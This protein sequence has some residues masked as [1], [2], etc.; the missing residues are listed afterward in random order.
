MNDMVVP[1]YTLISAIILP[2]LGLVIIYF[3][4]KL[5][6]KNGVR[7]ANRKMYDTTERI[8]DL[9]RALNLQLTKKESD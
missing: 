1:D 6:V 3:V 8:E 2:I 5:A 7:E 4:I 9:L